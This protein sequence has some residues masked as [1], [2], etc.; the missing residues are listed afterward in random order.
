MLR[1]FAENTLLYKTI[2]LSTNQAIL[3]ESTA[4]TPEQFYK[5]ILEK[6]KNVSLFVIFELQHKTNVNINL[7][8]LI[9]I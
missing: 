1:R 8:N 4:K 3:T 7:L 5:L 6:G 2:R 9:L